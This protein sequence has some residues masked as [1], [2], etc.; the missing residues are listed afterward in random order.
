MKV[1]HLLLV[2]AVLLLTDAASLRADVPF[3]TMRRLY[4]F[5]PVGPDNPV[6]AR[7]KDCGIEIPASELRAYV[8]SYV[9]DE[10]ARALSLAEKRHYLEGLIDD[11]LLLWNGYEQKADQTKGIAD[12]LR[13]TRG[14]LLEEALEDQVLKAQAK[15]GLDREETLRKF[16]DE[17]FSKINVEVSNQAYAKLKAEAHRIDATAGALEALGK[18]GMTRNDANPDLQASASVREVPLAHCPFGTITIGDFLQAYTR[19]P[20]PQRPDLDKQEGVIAVLKQ[21]LGSDLMVAEARARGLDKAAQF[22]EKLQLNR[23]VLTR[24]YALDQL[25]AR[26]VAEMKS[27]GIDARLKKWYEAHRKDYTATDKNGKEQPLS[28]SAVR[29]RVADEYFQDLQE[30]LRTDQIRVWRQQH[31]VEID[32]AALAKVVL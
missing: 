1:L 12:M 20:A 13:S 6:V 21:M 9:S 10:A 24:L 29:D 26:A 32:E 2:P 3:E 7:V 31:K 23:N 5:T 15:P 27:P 22:R 16:R 14:M 4:D 11:H 8:A 28:F 30:R 25:T 18:P 19:M 17:L